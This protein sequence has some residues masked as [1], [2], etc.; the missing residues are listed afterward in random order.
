MLDLEGLLRK[1]LREVMTS[2]QTLILPEGHDPRLI[3][4]ASKLIKFANIILVAD[5]AQV[6]T[7]VGRGEAELECADRRF[8]T[9]VRFVDPATDSLAPELAER[10]H[11]VSQ[12]KKWALSAPEAQERIL[13][14]VYFSI[15]AVREGYADA[16]LGG[17]AHSSREFFVPCLR[18]LEKEGTVY[19]MGIF[20]LPDDHPSGIYEQNVVMFADV[21]LTPVPQ[22]EDLAQIAV[23]ACRTMRD[24]IPVAALAEVNGALLSYSTRGSGQGASVERIRAAEPLIKKQLAVLRETNPIYETINIVTEMQISVALSETAARTKLKE[25]YDALP[26]AGHANVLI[27]PTL[28]VGNLLYH[29]YATRYPQ[30]ASTLIIGGLR[31]QA[32]DFSRSSTADDVA[33]GAK[34]LLLRRFRSDRYARTSKDHYFPRYRILTINPG[35]TSTKVALFDAEEL[36]AR[37]DIQHSQAELDTETLADQ[38]PLRRQVVVDF[39]AENLIGLDDLHA[40]V[41]R[42]GLCKPIESGTYAICETMAADLRQGVSGEHPSNLAG[43]IARDL[44]MS[45]GLPAFTVDPP[46][47]DE[48]DETSRISGHPEVTQEAAWHA[49]SQKAAAKHFADLRNREYE[50]L[51]LI[52]AHLGGG[53]SVGSHRQGR[54]VKVRNALFDGPMT[55]NRA[56]TLPGSDLIELCYS[57]ISRADLTKKLVGRGGLLAYLG[58]DDLREVERRIKAGDAEAAQIFDAMVEQIAAEIASHVP[59]LKGATIDR[60]ILTGGMCHSSLVRQ[61]LHRDLYPLGIKMTIFPG[62]REMEALRDGALRVLRGLEEARDYVPLRDKM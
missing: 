4:A 22:P 42:G 54:C 52:V 46:V 18:L 43:L 10:L 55:P 45:A 2:K 40:V 34:A 24:I 36:L 41:G 26:G 3:S 47:V 53:V 8:F 28:D 19:E 5:K 59:K 27:V 7:L 51:N 20:A 12:T 30:A 29:I 37:K 25:A 21:A 60:I 6:E 58:T 49:L 57:G 13:D 11:E 9:M 56:G 32:L 15:M 62:E 1:Q 50:D 38:L 31:N 14:P 23:G 16:V 39:L 33:R 61:R 44:A 35:S 48:L 17:L